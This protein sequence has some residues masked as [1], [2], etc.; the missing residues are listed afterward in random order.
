M[1]R[2]YSAAATGAQTR[3]CR[4]PGCNVRVH[5]QGIGFK[6]GLCM[7]HFNSLPPEAKE[8]VAE[9]R[10]LRVAKVPFQGSGLGTNVRL[11]VSL[12]REPWAKG[13][14]A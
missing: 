9:K 14:D 8:T 11:H 2:R 1:P 10:D 4:H 6:A 3:I 5:G 13:G 7:A 12:P